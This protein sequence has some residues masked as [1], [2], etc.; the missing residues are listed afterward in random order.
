[1]DPMDKLLGD[2]LMDDEGKPL[3]TAVLISP[4]KPCTCGAGFCAVESGVGYMGVCRGKRAD[5]PPRPDCPR[6]GA[7]HQGPGGCWLC[8]YPHRAPRDDGEGER[9]WLRCLREGVRGEEVFAVQ[10]EEIA[11]GRSPRLMGALDTVLANRRASAKE[12]G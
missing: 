1:M 4:G 9:F 12:Q 2:L 10:D 11:R 7:P 8:G 3:G 6:C 5:L